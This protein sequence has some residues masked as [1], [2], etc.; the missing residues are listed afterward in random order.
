MVQSPGFSVGEELGDGPCDL[1]EVEDG[2]PDLIDIGQGNFPVVRKVPADFQRMKVQSSQS[3]SSQNTQNSV[4]VIQQNVVFNHQQNAIGNTSNVNE[5]IM[6]AEERHNY[7]LTSVMQQAEAT[8]S[9]LLRKQRAEAE[10]EIQFA[11]EQ[12]EARVRAAESTAA[13]MRQEAHARFS[14]ME[15]E[16]RTRVERAYREGLRDSRVGS[17]TAGSDSGV[18]TPRSYHLKTPVRT[19]FESSKGSLVPIEFC[20]SDD[21]TS[22]VSN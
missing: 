18:S 17:T 14:E 19:P 3:S 5:T 10:A 21:N 11:K 1:M 6:V 12:A 20:M 9:E 16:T 4:N 15:A 2:L 22:L 7:V 13:A 8:H